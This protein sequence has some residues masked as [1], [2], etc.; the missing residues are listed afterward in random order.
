VEKALVMYPPLGTI[1]TAK[2]AEGGSGGEDRAG[3]ELTLIYN[4][5]VG[6]S[7]HLWQAR[8]PFGE[9]GF[10]REMAESFGR[11]WN[12][13]RPKKGAT[14]KPKEA[15]QALANSSRQFPLF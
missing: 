6:R 3:A 7:G 10:V 1:S 8:K 14:G 12:R 11:Y 4:V 2:H 5:R 13:G 9:T 15:E